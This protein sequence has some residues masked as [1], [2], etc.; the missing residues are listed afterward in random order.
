MGNTQLT[1]ESAGTLSLLVLG[2]AMIV[3]GAGTC[4]LKFGRRQ[5]IKEQKRAPRVW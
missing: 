1:L 3:C 5:C 4:W 2:L